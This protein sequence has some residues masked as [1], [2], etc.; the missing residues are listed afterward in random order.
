MTTIT[1]T[2]RQQLEEIFAKGL[3]R[4]LG[5]EDKQ[6]CVEGA[7][8][9]VMHGSL[10]DSPPCVASEDRTWA[11]FVNDALWASPEARAKALLPIALAQI[12]TEGTDRTAW[13]LAIT[14]GNVQRVFPIMLDI[15]GQPQEAEECSAV[16]D[17]TSATKALLIARNVISNKI[18]RSSSAC[19]LS[20]INWHFVIKAIRS[21]LDAISY[22][23]STINYPARAAA[24]DAALSVAY[25][26]N[27][28]AGETVD[29]AD[30]I[31]QEAVQVALDAYAAEGTEVQNDS[32]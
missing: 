15:I 13:V 32:D 5:S 20:N 12:G 17:L 27:A 19:L 23:L 31:L 28:I 10:S 26:A 21:A 22:A 16:V 18:S 29:K 7:I 30:A 9:L 14:L 11:I 24:H 6:T 25:A 1:E 3:S 2:Q 4:G 8:S